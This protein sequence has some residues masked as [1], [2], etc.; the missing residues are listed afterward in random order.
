MSFLNN[1]LNRSAFTKNVVTLVTGQVIAQGISF[2]VG[3][4]ITRI[5]L[6][7]Q[8]GAYSLFVTIANIIAIAATGRYDT[9]IVL[10]ENKEDVK[11]LWVLSLLISL[12]FNI[13]LFL[14]L[15]FF[16]SFIITSFNVNGMGKWLL[17]LPLAIFGI[18]VVQA[19][20][21]Y[22]NKYAHYPIIKKSEV[23]RSSFNSGFSVF[24]G[25]VHFLAGGLILAN[26]IAVLSTATY[27][28]VQL[29]KKF[30]F[31]LF[32]YMRRDALMEVANRYK[33]YLRSYTFS[34]LLN[35][36]VVNGTP[37]FLVYFFSEKI[38]GYYFIAEKALNIPIALVVLSISKVFYQKGTELYKEDKA[39]FLKL[40]VGIQKKV[41]LFL[42]PFLLILS[43]FGPFI[44]Q[45]FG[46]GWFFAGGLVK[47]FAVF[48]LFCNLLSPVGTVA[49][50]IDRLDIFLYFNIAIVVFRFLTFYI[51]SLYLTFEYALLLS[52][53]VIACCYII[54]DRSLKNIIRS[55]L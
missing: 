43:I 45:L 14:L 40:M 55:Q 36:L 12:S 44:F 33:V 7:E 6:P 10:E 54:F 51:G 26:L 16:H 38:A 5:Y 19:T 8:I 53:V 22:F 39:A 13:I 11:K 50:I 18:T 42:V 4:I 1:I 15:Y 41:A 28:L 21:F 20:Q 37:F 32:Q 23:L 49:N 25:L 47:Y 31:G 30:F 48:L 24:F 35:A 34:G 2:G 17:L 46:E 52:S 27:L 29:P 9:A 3:F